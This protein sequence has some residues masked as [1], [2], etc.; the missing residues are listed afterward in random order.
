MKKFNTL[1]VVVILQA[2]SMIALT[3]FVIWDMWIVPKGNQSNMNGQIT[4]D[5]DYINH[6][7]EVVASIAKIPILKKELVAELIELYGDDTLDQL[8]KHRAIDIAAKE[9]QI[10]VSSSELEQAVAEAA[11]G[12]ESREQYFK[13]IKNQLGFSQHKAI[14]EIHYQLLLE[15]IATKDIEV[16]EE[17][18][19]MYMASHQ[20]RYNEH[21]VVRLSWI[22][23]YDQKEAFDMLDLLSSGNPFAE[24]A[25]Q[26]SQ[27][28]YSAQMGGDLGEITDDDPFYDQLMLQE[29]TRMNVGDIMGPLEVSDGYAIIYLTGKKSEEPMSSEQQR[30]L[31][32]RDITLDRAGALSEVA[33]QLM[34]KYGAVIKK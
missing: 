12:Y 22:L 34:Q 5:N 28:A 3:G 8:L 11:S 15:K 27:D 9:F 17:E 32:I 4:E 20:D 23:T 7:E 16:S 13:M 19:E 24:L 30:E 26:Y 1:K 29:A 10:K 6:S 33:D 2:V 18:I 21:V 31:A 25:K 14:E